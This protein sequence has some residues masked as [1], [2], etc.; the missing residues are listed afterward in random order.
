M[1]MMSDWKRSENRNAS[2]KSM[3]EMYKC[4][5][6]QKV[7]KLHQQT[8]LGFSHPTIFILKSIKSASKS[9]W[10]KKNKKQEPTSKTS[11]IKH[12]IWILFF[13]FKWYIYV[14]DFM[15]S[16]DKYG[17][18]FL[19]H[20]FVTAIIRFSMN[21]SLFTFCEICIG[22]DRRSVYC[23]AHPI[24]AFLKTKMLTSQL[25]SVKP[26]YFNIQDVSPPEVYGT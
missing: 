22:P 13:S 21:N 8:F 3:W 20:P 14:K 15:A 5:K 23:M 26:K 18:V 11:Q 19:F 16:H 2:C 17:T 7:L 10:I 25:K 6:Q 9:K 1:S 24:K 12:C 4:A